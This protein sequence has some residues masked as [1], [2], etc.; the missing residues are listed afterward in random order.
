MLGEIFEFM[1]DCFPNQKLILKCGN[2]ELD[3]EKIK[4]IEKAQ[5]TDTC[6]ICGDEKPI[7][8]L[9]RNCGQ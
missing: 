5:E 2:I 4:E 9:H 1:N 6:S 3:E 8:N 7:G